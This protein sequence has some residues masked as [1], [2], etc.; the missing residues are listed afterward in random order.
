MMD[1]VDEI[2]TYRERSSIA[3]AVDVFIADHHD[4][5]IIV[6]SRP[7]GYVRLAGEIPHFQMPNFSPEQVKTFVHNWQRAFELWKHPQSP[8]FAAAEADADAMVAEIEG[9]P[10][11]TEL[12]ANPLMLVIISLIRLEKAR[13]PDQRVQLYYRA[14][15]TL[16]DT[17]NYWRSQAGADVGGA[18]LPLEQ[19]IRVW[20]AIAEWTR[21]T[22]PTGVIHRAELKR[23]L[24]RVLEEKELDDDNAAA[25][26]E[27]YTEHGHKLSF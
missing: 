6:T 1:G 3:Q 16:L 14:V 10:K 8:N 26:A 12:A 25:T 2:P 7:F 5:R 23:Q 22:K 4:N 21:R 15:N 20:G 19:L 18:T 9:N 17:W 24:V 27:S 13:L 11:V